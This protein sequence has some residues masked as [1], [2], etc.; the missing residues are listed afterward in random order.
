MFTGIAPDFI[1]HVYSVNSVLK[2]YTVYSVK[3]VNGNQQL[4]DILRIEKYAGKSNAT[5]IDDYLRIRTATSWNKSEQVTGLRPTGIPRLF[6][7]NR[8]NE[9]CPKT[10]L[11][12]GFNNDR[13]ELF[14]D[15]YRGFYPHHSGILQNIIKTYR[16]Q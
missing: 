1:R 16:R 2:T 7:G 10:L 11:I 4:P 14:I 8:K 5:G 6:H 13:S 12:F 15:V 9:S 3:E